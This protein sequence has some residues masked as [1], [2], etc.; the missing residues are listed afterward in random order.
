[1]R[2]GRL[3]REGMT[4]LMS[5][6]TRTF[7]MAL[8]TV[9]GIGALTV[10]LFIS[11][12]TKR[13]VAQK[14][15]RFGARA[16]LIVPAH[17]KMSQAVGGKSAEAK[18]KLADAKAIANQIEGLDG[19]S[20]ST[21]RY[22]QPVKAGAVQTT[23]NVDAVEANWHFVWDWPVAS[24]A[25][26]TQ[27][28][29]DQLSRVCV[30]GATPKVELFGDADPIGTEILIGNV[31][32]KVKGV[33]ASRGITGTGHDRDRRIVIPFSTGMRR[34]FN[35]QHIS[36]IR[37]KVNADYDLD[38]TARSIEALLYQRH[39]IDP[40]IESVFT[41]FSTN[42]LV[43]RFKGV[44]DTVSRLLI[45]L[46]GLS[47]LVGGLVLMNIMLISVAERK[48]EIGLRK[49][50]GAARRDILVQFL[51]EAVAVNGLGLVLGWC[52]GMLTA[53]IIARFTQIP[54]APSVLSFVLGG[55]FSM[56][57]ALVFSLQPA[58]RAANLDPVEAIR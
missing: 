8:G 28:D 26:I 24:G 44:S 45:A 55:V 40:A 20:A 46:C 3:F 7:L 6:K 37:V 21:S 29:V 2:T 32:F 43:K 30:L 34:L 35:Q 41:V 27:T 58:R 54:V 18:L 19:I 17:G 15:E 10:I 56:G 33:L 9:V 51:M 48:A 53:W 13:E 39:H 11:A 14:A 23:T 4:A 57:V 22:S 5:N 31:W 47:F 1:M 38:A 16:I 52:L 42:S 36:N 25:P 49:A 50:L 12:G